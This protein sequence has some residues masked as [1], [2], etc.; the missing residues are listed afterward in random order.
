MTLRLS[1]LSALIAASF[2]ATAAEPIDSKRAASADAR[3][4]I[5][6]VRG[7]IEVTAWE[8]NEV[9]IGG[10][11]GEGSKLDVSGS[12]G[13]IVIRVEDP[14]SS[15][16]SWWGSS[17]PKEDTVLN[18][19]VPTRAS[20]D[21]SAVSAD[22]SVTGVSGR[23]LN[24][25][26]VSGDVRIEADGDELELSSVSGDVELRTKSR[27][28]S[29]ET[30]SGDLTVNGAGG[31]V[32]LESVSGRIRAE[33]DAVEDF[34][35]GTVSGDADL[36]V[37]AASRGRVKAESMSGDVDLAVPASISATFTAETF[38]GSIRSDFGTV[39]DEEH[40][41][42]SNLQTKTGDG[43]VT[44]DVESFSGDVTIRKQ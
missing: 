38:S 15:G 27:F 29:A 4:E 2:H 41:S 40:G 11:L 17:G 1:L 12:D 10:S 26:S 25:E 14:G 5:E 7:R 37:A 44:I 42:G 16:W 36:V 18:V 43:T 8:R 34:V 13:H 23:A 30:V 39:V 32:H 20:V 6:N 33:T 19:K 31:R 24:V 3:V 9:A 35:V 28:V 22:V 21:A